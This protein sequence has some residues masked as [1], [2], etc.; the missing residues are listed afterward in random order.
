MLLVKEQSII[1]IR[2][3]PF[4]PR[5]ANKWNLVSVGRDTFIKTRD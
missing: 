1:D 5:S 4:P 3:S 2:Q